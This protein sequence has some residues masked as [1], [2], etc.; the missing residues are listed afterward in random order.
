MVEGDSLHTRFWD[1][2]C[3]YQTVL[4]GAIG[5]YAILLVLLVLA[6]PGIERGTG[7]FVILVV[8]FVLLGVA[9]AVTA[10]LAWK[11][12]RRKRKRRF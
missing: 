1:I 10:G 7:S 8:D 6:L 2:V 5:V 11:C 9:F 4:K 12:A 3:D